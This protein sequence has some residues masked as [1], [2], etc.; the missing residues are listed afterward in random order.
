MRGKGSGF[1]R[2]DRSKAVDGTLMPL[3]WG[4]GTIRMASWT[5]A[6]G[7]PAPEILEIPGAVVVRFQRATAQKTRE[8]TR[9][10]G[11]LERVGP[12]KGGSWRV[13]R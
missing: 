11:R 8:K 5:Q 6:A 12:D 1:R 3:T 13:L 4:Q 7:F 10:S 2:A 9:E